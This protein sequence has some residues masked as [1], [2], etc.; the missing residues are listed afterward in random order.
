MAVKCNTHLPKICD[1]YFIQYSVES[2]KLH[3]P[4]AWDKHIRSVWNLQDVSDTDKP[5]QRDEMNKW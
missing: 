1:Q 3:V 5:N 4:V 2:G